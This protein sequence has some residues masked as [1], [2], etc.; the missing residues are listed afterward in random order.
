MGRASNRVLQVKIT[1]FGLDSSRSRKSVFQL[2]K[3]H[4]SFSGH[5]RIERIGQVIMQA[6]IFARFYRGQTVRVPRRDT[7]T[8]FPLSPLTKRSRVAPPP[9]G[10]FSILHARALF[11]PR[12]VPNCK[13]N[14]IGKGGAIAPTKS[15][16]Q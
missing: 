1:S 15:F 16:D 11:P 4:T 8:L 2:F 3:S 13:Q 6:A 10:L 14:G 12:S 7:K 9:A 5:P